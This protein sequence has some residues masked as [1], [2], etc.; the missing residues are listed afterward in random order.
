V[1]IADEV[2]DALETPRLSRAQSRLL[3]REFFGR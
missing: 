3:Y 1:K 2:V